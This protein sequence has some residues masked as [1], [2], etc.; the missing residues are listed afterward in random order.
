MK[1]SKARILL[2]NLTEDRILQHKREKDFYIEYD[3]GYF[4][5]Y[6]NGTITEVNGIE[7]AETVIKHHG[8]RNWE[9][10]QSPFAKRHPLLA[11]II[12]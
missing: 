4:T 7:F 12:D 2:E 1:K 11:T 3:K 8:T 6:R 10:I 5:I 9:I